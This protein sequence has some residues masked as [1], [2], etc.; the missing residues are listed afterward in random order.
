MPSL[1]SPWF[2]AFPRNAR[3]THF[4]RFADNVAPPRGEM[5]IRYRDDRSFIRFDE[6]TRYRFRWKIF[7][8]SNNE[9]KYTIRYAILSRDSDCNFYWTRRKFHRNTFIEEHF[10]NWRYIYV[11]SRVLSRLFDSSCRVQLIRL[12][13]RVVLFSETIRERNHAFTNLQNWSRIGFFGEKERDSSR[14]TKIDREN[15]R[16]ERFNF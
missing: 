2:M 4:S 5:I 10:I 8:R 15:S 14:E 3:S 11:T 13:V 1:F 12:G 7:L 6:E 16:G 9:E